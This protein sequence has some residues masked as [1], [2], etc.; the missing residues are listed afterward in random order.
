MRHWLLDKLGLPRHILAMLDRYCRATGN[1][2]QSAIRE[3]LSLWAHEHQDDE[4]NR[5]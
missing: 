1:P 4:W 3:A 5:N 2:V